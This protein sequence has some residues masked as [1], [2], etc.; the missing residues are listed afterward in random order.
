MTALRFEIVEGEARPTG[1]ATDLAAASDRLPAGAYTTLRTYGGR[2]TVRFE[3]HLRRLEESAGGPSG[4]LDRRLVGGALAQAVA[5]AGHPESRLRITYAPPRLFVAV[6]AFEALPASLY[7][8][9]AWCV[10]VPLRRQ[11]PKL[12]DTRFLAT[13][14]EAR[15]RLPVGA[16]EGLLVDEDGGL[17]EGLSSNFFAVRDGRLH[18]EEER[19]LNGVTREL[20]LEVA[21][22]L[23]PRGEGPAFLPDVPSLEEAFITSVSRGILAVTRIDEH[24]IG[25]G[26]G[27]ITRELASRFDRLL[28]AEAEPLEGGSEPGARRP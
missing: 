20:I 2:A 16:H 17:L 14:E 3:R 10:T 13:A 6:E 22:P 7:G 11:N 26:P 1:E 28:E 9:G 18:T 4:S 24:R 25:A 23:L 8:G 19:A 15:A 12:K 27:P 21:R 5:A